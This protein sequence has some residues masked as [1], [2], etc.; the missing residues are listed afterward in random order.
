MYSPF[1]GKKKAS[2]AEVWNAFQISWSNWVGFPT[3]V[4]MDQDGSFRGEFGQQLMDRGIIV[5]YVPRDAHGGIAFVE[6]RIRHLKLQLES[7]MGDMESAL[8]REQ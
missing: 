2:A 1:F 4:W 6:N 8:L 3:E 7:E 5:T